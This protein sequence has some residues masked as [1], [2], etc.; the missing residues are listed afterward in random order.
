MLKNAHD[1]SFPLKCTVV[2]L[3]ENSNL[4]RNKPQN[5]SAYFR[6]YCVLKKY[7]KTFNFI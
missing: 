1:F 4:S 5:V 2:P 7:V 3:K 6:A